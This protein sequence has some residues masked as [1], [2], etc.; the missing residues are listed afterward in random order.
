[1]VQVALWGSLKAAAGGAE[2]VEIEATNIR[3][4]LKGLS[5]AHPGLAPVIESGVA[6]S[7]DG[8]LH[9][10]NWF[11]EIPAESEVYVLPYME[12]G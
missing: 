1:M 2:T 7:I 10:D 3:Q 12:G 8:E 6:V 4:L 11:A 5:E 9:Q